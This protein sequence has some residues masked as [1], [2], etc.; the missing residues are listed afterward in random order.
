MSNT[1]DKLKEAL[2]YLLP[3]SIDDVLRENRQEARLYLSTPEELAVL[4]GD[5]E[6]HHVKGNISD[7]CFVSFQIMATGQVGVFLVG[8]NNEERAAWMT[9][10]VTTIAGKAVMTRSG[11]LYVLDG[12][13]TTEPNLLHICATL[14]AWGAGQHFD[15]PHIFY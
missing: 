9:S 3:K 12:E 14:H 8:H 2:E 13:P 15:V 5:I 7:W 1:A 10:S 4:V 11:S 6:M